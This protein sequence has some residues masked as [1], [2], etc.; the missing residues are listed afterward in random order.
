MENLHTAFGPRPESPNSGQVLG[1]CVSMAHIAST[2]SMR[3]AATIRVRGAEAERAT[4][5]LPSRPLVRPGVLAGAAIVIAMS[6]AA[7]EPVRADCREAAQALKEAIAGGDLDAVESRFDAVLH[8]GSCSDGFR[9]QAGR[10]VSMVH[11]RVVQERMRAGMSLSSQRSV[12]ERGLGYA[13][14]WP[15]LALLGDAAH[16][17]EAWD[18]AS[19]RYQEALVAIDDTMRT[20]KPPPLSEIERIYRRAAQSRLLAV[21]YRPPPRTRSGAPGGLAAENIR[22][23][24]IERVP[25]PITFHT[26]SADFTEKGRSAAAD[27]L[28]YLTIQKSDRITIVGHTDPRGEHAYNLALSQRRAEAVAHYLRVNGFAGQVQVVAKGE[29]ER[30]PVDDPSAYSREQRW[31]MDRRVE[32]IR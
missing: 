22:G 4:E 3:P 28:E 21:D 10:A 7:I 1:D 32:L 20:P 2:R 30:F 27:M 14:T 8:E 11:A 26:D 16:D 25:V 9:A 15:V 23:F 19:A 12:L 17:A 6:T 29:T 31:Q 18:E 24:A 5:I 13:R